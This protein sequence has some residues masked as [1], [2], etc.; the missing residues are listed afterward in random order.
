MEELLPLI[1]G[2]LQVEVRDIDSR[3]DW[4]EAYS[5]LIP[6][7]RFENRQICHYS[8]DRPAIERIVHDTSVSIKAS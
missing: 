4:T 8:L 2:R 7:V 3:A 5:R 1:R 6:V